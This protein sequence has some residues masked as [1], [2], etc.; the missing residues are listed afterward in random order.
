[1]C[2]RV[3][4]VFG[5]LMAIVLLFSACKTPVAVPTASSSAKP[6]SEAP[7]VQLPLADDELP[8]VA[9]T[10]YEM[11]ILDPTQSNTIRPLL[12]LED[13]RKVLL[14]N[15]WHSDKEGL[16]MFYDRA[17][18]LLVDKDYQILQTKALPSNQAS[19][20]GTSF[21]P[22]KGCFILGDTLQ[23][24]DENLELESLP[25]PG[26]ASPFEPHMTKDGTFFIKDRVIVFD[27]WPTPRPSRLY[28]MERG[29][30]PT[31]AFETPSDNSRWR[32][33]FDPADL[34]GQ[35]RVYTNTGILRMDDQGNEQVL[36]NDLDELSNP[37]T[38]LITRSSML[39]KIRY[40]SDGRYAYTVFAFD[41]MNFLSDLV[42]PN[43]TPKDVGY[44]EKR[45]CPFMLRYVVQEDGSLV[46]EDQE[47]YANYTVS[48]TKPPPFYI[49]Y[50]EDVNGNG[51]LL[52]DTDV[53]DDE[54][55]YYEARPIEK[56]GIEDEA[57]IQYAIPRAYGVTYPC[58]N[59]DKNRLSMAKIR[60][61]ATL[62]FLTLD[63][64]NKAT[65]LFL[66]ET[67]HMLAEGTGQGMNRD[68]IVQFDFSHQ[69]PEPVT[70]TRKTIT[71]YMIKD[72][73][74]F[75]E[76]VSGFEGAYPEYRVDITEF[77]KL[78]DLRTR[79]ATEL[80]AGKGPDIVFCSPMPFLN[81]L[82]TLSNGYFLDL[83]PYIDDAPDFNMEDYFPQ[84]MSAGVI[85]GKRYLAP[86]N[87]NYWPV[88][89]TQTMLDKAELKPGDSLPVDKLLSLFQAHT[90][91]LLYTDLQRLV[92]FHATLK[93]FKGYEMLHRHW[94]VMGISMADALNERALFDQPA[95]QKAM[96]F[97]KTL[98][99]EQGMLTIGAPSLA[100]EI[101][102][103]DVLRWDPT[104]PFS[105]YDLF[106]WESDMKAEGEQGALL[107][108]PS[109]DNTAP[110]GII[111]NALVVNANAK[112]KDGAVQLVRFALEEDIQAKSATGEHLVV[113]VNKNALEKQI[114]RFMNA[115]EVDNRI[116]EEYIAPYRTMIEQSGP[117]QLPD[118][119]LESMVED[120]VVQYLQDE[121]TLEQMTKEL[122]QK[123]GLYLKE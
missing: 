72:R 102:G 28:T 37:T 67:E 92:S 94:S 34:S 121:I 52:Q 1:M 39:E 15:S 40:S 56:D 70:D 5:C 73:E 55:S 41:G 27:T 100:K 43:H 118:P 48:D 93:D 57:A 99:N 103:N 36:F 68:A 110:S 47:M 16:H 89:T 45:G 31:L 17:E 29:A 112:E 50:V 77:E 71:A 23:L 22:G 111:R 32:I 58:V 114:Q 95:F 79:L 51:Y 122:M 69:E 20:E 106:G 101:P 82:K 120:M 98:Y 117:C 85:E 14:A 113:P 7:P 24:V 86:L 90:T 12:E 30:A 10:L 9:Q 108:M 81:P 88:Y 66:N 84:A 75:A 42:F 6:G 60:L 74:G 96:A 8:R 65:G 87:F 49:D 3:C 107:A 44:W 64:E 26:I 21:F 115:T 91:P 46:F 2:K 38:G 80:M 11:E 53:D 13:G 104:R 54:Y 109:M 35:F 61:Q 19:C 4:F 76:I 25:L 119:E 33:S 78:D 97:L 123:V 63:A 105:G 116:S 62:G 83:A 18:L 59:E